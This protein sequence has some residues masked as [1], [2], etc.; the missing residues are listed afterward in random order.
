MK[1]L[2]AIFFTLFLFC[3]LS[4]FAQTGCIASGIPFQSDGT[5]YLS[6]NG[7]TGYY[8]LY[9][10]K[11]TTPYST[12]CITATGRSCLVRGL[13][14]YSGTEVTYGPFPC[15][16]DSNLYILLGCCGLYFVIKVNKRKFP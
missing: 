12:Y 16:V 10:A 6:Y 15:P 11:S 4:L 1:N 8:D 2:K 13:G 3:N 7:S 9:G 5:M 14:V